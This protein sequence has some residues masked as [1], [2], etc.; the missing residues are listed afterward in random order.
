MKKQI[1]SYKHYMYLEDDVLFTK[2]NFDH[3]LKWH[4]ACKKRN[5][6]LGFLR[7]E[8]RD[9]DKWFLGDLL[10]RLSDATEIDG[11]EFLRCNTYR[12]AAMW[13][14][15]NE[16]MKKFA[17][18]MSDLYEFKQLHYNGGISMSRENAAIGPIYEMF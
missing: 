3:Y 8:C 12:Y 6:Y 17:Y 15:D 7:V 14:L 18:E 5:A 2:K 4:E 13:I 10:E 11:T 1:G 9:D 16:E